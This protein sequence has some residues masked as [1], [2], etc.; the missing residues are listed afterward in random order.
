MDTAL[1]ARTNMARIGI[2][3]ALVGV[4][5]NFYDGE[6]TGIIAAILGLVL[7][8]F[9]DFCLALYHE[10]DDFTD[11][12]PHTLAAWFAIASVVSVGASLLIW[13]LG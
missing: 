13:V 12:L 8:Y 3:I 2:V 11:E 7:G 4:F 6:K 10:S 1:A 9:A 5:L